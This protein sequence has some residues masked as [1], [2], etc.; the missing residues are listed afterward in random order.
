MLNPDTSDAVYQV[1]AT[2]MRN[3]SQNRA[4]G[5][6]LITAAAS[7]GLAAGSLLADRGEASPVH[8]SAEPGRQCWHR[9]TANTR[10][11]V[12]SGMAL[13]LRMAGCW[14]ARG[15]C[16]QTDEGQIIYV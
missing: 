2:I 8:R 12:R 6:R 9:S 7:Q 16:Q 3:T 1:N 4:F 14:L 13:C 10:A 5:S 11:S 15:Q